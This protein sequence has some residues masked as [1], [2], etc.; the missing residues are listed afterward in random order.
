MASAQAPALKFRPSLSTRLLETGS[1]AKQ[2]PQMKKKTNLNTRFGSP[3]WWWLPKRKAGGNRIAG[4]Q[5][6]R[7]ESREKRTLWK[8]RTR[9]GEGLRSSE[10]V[11][12]RTNLTV[13]VLRHDRR[14]QLQKTDASKPE[15]KTEPIRRLDGERRFINGKK[16]RKGGEGRKQRRKREVLCLKG[17]KKNKN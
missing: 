1:Y 16:K 10:V 5:E 9:L 2:M 4:N 6:E 8:E 14:P 13:V 3:L 7:K 11:S 12:K 15:Q 17:K